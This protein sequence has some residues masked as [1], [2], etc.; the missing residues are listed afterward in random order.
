MSEWEEF[1]GSNGWSI[2]SSDDYDDCLDSI[3]ASSDDS[4][5][6]DDVIGCEKEGIHPKPAEIA[7][8]GSYAYFIIE[9]IIQKAMLSNGERFYFTEN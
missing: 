5:D 6:S 1:C 4:P 7:L 8:H 2:G 9:N 3:E